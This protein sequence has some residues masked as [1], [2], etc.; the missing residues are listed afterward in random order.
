MRSAYVDQV[1]HED[2]RLV[3]PDDATRAAL[4]VGEVRRGRDAGAATDLHAR[5]ALVPAGDHLAA[6]EAEL[7]RVAAIPRCVELLA[8]L[9]RDADVMDLDD[10]ARDRLL[11]LADRQVLDLELVGGRSVGDADVGLLG[12]VHVT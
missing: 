1:D 2:Q 8:G 6:A 7:E 9:P 12:G 11:A 4:A 3:G 10:P 5:D